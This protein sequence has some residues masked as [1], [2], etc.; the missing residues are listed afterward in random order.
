M[1]PDASTR[2]R[3]TGRAD[4]GCTGL[5]GVAARPPPAWARMPASETGPAG[6]ME[7][8]PRTAARRTAARWN[9]GPCPRTTSGPHPPGTG[10]R[11]GRPD[12]RARG[13]RPG[14]IRAVSRQARCPNPD[15]ITST[16]PHAH[17]RSHAGRARRHK[18]RAAQRRP[19][20]ASRATPH[21]QAPARRLTRQRA[22]TS[23]SAASRPAAH[24]GSKQWLK[25]GRCRRDAAN[26][27]RESRPSQGPAA[28]SSAPR[29]SVAAMKNACRGGARHPAGISRSRHVG[30][31]RSPSRWRR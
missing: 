17:A 11:P 13:L 3:R 14:V 15:A 25:A 12:G 7:A 6:G 23:E 26:R 31:R 1:G 21:A 9:G 22:G 27:R 30:I 4:L 29:L 19:S 20:N 18:A 28:R 8:M 16:S 2:A 5:G 10:P 24:A